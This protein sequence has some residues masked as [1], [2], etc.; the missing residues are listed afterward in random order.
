MG[1]FLELRE[2][3]SGVARVP[4]GDRPDGAVRNE[5]GTP[6]GPARRPGQ[7]VGYR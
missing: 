2:F 3:V 1:I 6:L 4:A 7:P 5:F